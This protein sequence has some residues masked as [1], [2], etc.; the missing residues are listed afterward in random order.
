MMNK[1][2][3]IPAAMALCVALL[4]SCN[5]FFTT[6]W[7]KDN[8]RD[9]SKI[10]VTADNVDKLLKNAKGD[11]ATSKGILDKIAEIPNPDDHLKAAAVT[12]AK[13]AS[14]LSEALMGSIG[15]LDIDDLA[16]AALTDIVDSLQ[17]ATADKNLP[18][19]ADDIGKILGPVSTSSTP[20]FT[21]PAFLENI[22]EGD[23]TVL[24][25][26]LI[27]AKVEAEGVTFD[28]YI[29]TTLAGKD[30]DDASTLDTD[31]VVIIALV[32]ALA[33]KSETLGDMLD[34]FLG[35]A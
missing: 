24:V 16:D 32:N 27:L 19:I 23:L 5:G 17:A 3:G 12:A 18:G 34:A 29:N 21:D 6:S 30:L 7:A 20:E 11:T 22:S 9:P 1:K 25:V 26:A 28:Y 4:A 14:G 13:Q 2:I 33:D 35:R 8:A 10:K 31:E 15:D